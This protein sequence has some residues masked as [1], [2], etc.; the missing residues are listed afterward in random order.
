MDQLTV[1][2]NQQDFV[3]ASF[4]LQAEKL[5]PLGEPTREQWRECGRFLRLAEGNIHFWIGDWLIYGQAHF[6]EDYEEAIALTGYSY[7]TLRKDKY[8]AERIPPERR[9]P[10]V[11]VAIHQEVASLP[12]SVQEKLL[13]RAENEQLSV[14]QLRMPGILQ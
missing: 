11:D 9:R 14:Q 6:K 3:Y 5:F 4:R 2:P 1:K 7:H 8:T 13:Q 10:T 12:P